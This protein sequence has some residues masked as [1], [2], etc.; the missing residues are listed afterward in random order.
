[1][2]SG[3]IYAFM[4]C[5]A[6]S[7]STDAQERSRLGVAKEFLLFWATPHR[8][9]ATYWYWCE[10]APWQVN[11]ENPNPNSTSAVGSHMRN[12]RHAVSSLRRVPG[13]QNASQS[14]FK[15]GPEEPGEAAALIRLHPE[16]CR[17]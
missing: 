6:L 7:I 1:M 16:S 8:G 14:G 11:G 4:L 15:F 3:R 12:L 10:V 13:A 9:T 5:S 2:A 17:G